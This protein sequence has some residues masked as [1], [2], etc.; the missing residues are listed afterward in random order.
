MLEH[1][2]KS[3]LWDNKP[4][5]NK[6]DERCSIILVKS[7]QKMRKTTR[8]TKIGKWIPQFEKLRTVDNIKKER[9]KKVLLWYLS[10]LKD[11]YVQKVYSADGFRSKFFQIEAAMIQV[12][13]DEEEKDDFE[14]KTYRK[15]NIITDIIH[16]DS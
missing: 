10:H 9:I 16:Y 5:V 15:G 2:K 13:D 8:R 14:I 11:R 1:Y 3:D 6:F 12:G 4:Q 7:I